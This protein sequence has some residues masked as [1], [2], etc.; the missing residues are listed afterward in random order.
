MD[1]RAGINFI[2]QEQVFHLFSCPFHKV[3]TDF[4]EQEGVFPG[5]SCP[6]LCV[7]LV[8]LQHCKFDLFGPSFSVHDP[9]AATAT[10]QNPR[11]PS[12]SLSGHVQCRR[13]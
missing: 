5:F 12:Q 8:K 13:A 6:W 10:V 9:R 2:E 7:H 3:G 4:M 11:V 1:F